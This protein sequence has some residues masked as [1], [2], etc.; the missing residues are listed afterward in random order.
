[1]CFNPC[2]IPWYDV[3]RFVRFW[4]H[5][6]VPAQHYLVLK[7]CTPQQWWTSFLAP[8]RCFQAIILF[9]VAYFTVFVA[10]ANIHTLSRALLRPHPFHAFEFKKWWWWQLLS[11][12]CNYISLSH[13]ARWLVTHSIQSYVMIQQCHSCLLPYRAHSFFNPFIRTMQ[14]HIITHMDDPI[15]NPTKM[16]MWHLLMRMLA[17]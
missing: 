13:V 1:M 2:F 9:P 8:L 12:G 6:P 3:C 14:N 4:K 15:Q 11:C 10:L 17:E 7:N 5:V 16:G